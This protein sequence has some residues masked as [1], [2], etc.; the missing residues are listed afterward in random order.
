MEI[1]WV[2]GVTKVLDLSM[3]YCVQA[4]MSDYVL[5]KAHDEMMAHVLDMTSLGNENFSDVQH[6][7]VLQWSNYILACFQTLM[8][9]LHYLIYD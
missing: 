4:H 5:M 8:H 1:P 3:I 7:F 2:I 6:N 9:K